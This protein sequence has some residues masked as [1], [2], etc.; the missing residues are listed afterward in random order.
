M[1]ITLYFRDGRSDKIYRTA[2]EDR[3]GGHVVTFAYGRRGSM[4]ATGTKTNQ[5]VDFDEQLKRF[6]CSA[7]FE[8]MESCLGDNDRNWRVCQEHV[9]IFKLCM[10]DKAANFTADV[11][12][13]N[14]T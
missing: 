14:K 12:D 9:R 11:T 6:G 2:I 8:R 5:P 10:K 7:D 13:N 4:L 1:N 3:A